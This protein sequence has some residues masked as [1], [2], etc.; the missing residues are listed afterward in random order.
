MKPIRFSNHAKLQMKLRGASESEVTAAIKSG[1]WVPAKMAKSKTRF[2]FDF[3]KPAPTNQKLY[4]YKIVEPI[5]VDAVRGGQIPP[6]KCSL[7][8]D[9]IQKYQYYVNDETTWREVI[10]CY[11]TYVSG[12]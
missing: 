3:N 10:T 2:R 4:K 1:N 12:L 11:N 8:E 9:V 6:P 7:W 5:F